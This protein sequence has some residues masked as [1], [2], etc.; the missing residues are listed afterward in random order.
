MNA[1]EQMDHSASGH[2]ARRWTARTQGGRQAAETSGL[3]DPTLQS[4]RR[5]ISNQVPE[6][7]AFWT[8][9]YLKSV[10][11]KKKY[12]VITLKD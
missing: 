6:S 1:D 4:H 11:K 8:Y 2:T 3:L 12:I 9:S 10:L 5:M 7:D